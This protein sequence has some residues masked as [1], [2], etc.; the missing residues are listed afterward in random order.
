MALAAYDC[1]RHP[2]HLQRLHSQLPNSVIDLLSDMTSF[3]MSTVAMPST[4]Q[5]WMALAKAHDAPNK[6][7]EIICK[8]W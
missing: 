4:A 5:L 7:Q 3:D 2:C 6:T 1:S 8:V